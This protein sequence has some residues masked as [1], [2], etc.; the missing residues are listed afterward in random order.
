MRK[1]HLAAGVLFVLVFLATGLYM[2]SNFAANDEI[3]IA[4]RLLHR[5]AHIYILFAALLNLAVGSGYPDNL[6]GW[7]R[8]FRT[9]ASLLLFAAPCAFTA[10]FF[11]EPGLVDA[12]THVPAR[13]YALPGVAAS[14]LAIALFALVSLGRTPRRNSDE[15]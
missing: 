8:A 7:R 9:F 15:I 13:P 10:A 2:R 12:D 11:I 1:L 14:L 5:T 4:A 6:A 3:H